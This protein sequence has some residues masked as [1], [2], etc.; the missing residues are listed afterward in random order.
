M[1]EKSVI[2]LITR[3]LA[4]ETTA[5]EEEELRY[6]LSVDADAAEYFKVC[7]DIWQNN[8]GPGKESA[9]DAFEK[10]LK[11]FEEDFREESGKEKRFRL[12]T[13]HAIQK[14]VWLAAA[15]LLLLA[16]AGIFW[17][18]V[19]TRS[20]Q[21]PDA[22]LAKNEVQS[23]NNRKR[24]LLPDSTVVWLNKNSRL[25]FSLENFSRDNRTVYLEGEGFFDVA[26]MKDHPFIIHTAGMDI[27]VLGTSF[28]V[29]AYQLDP[30]ETTL[31]SGAVELAVNNREKQ[32]LVLK[33]GEKCTLKKT[34]SMAVAGQQPP[35]QN[36]I[37]GVHVTGIEPVHFY[38]RDYIQEI[39]WM[40][41]QLVF[42]N[43]SFAE[44][45]Q[46]MSQWF[47]IPVTIQNNAYNQYHFTGAFE[48][49]NITEALKALQTI[50]P[51][52]Y[53]IHQNGVVIF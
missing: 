10:H 15:C 19:T 24:L 20:T 43:K 21:Q 27:K 23:G 22:L 48:K 49:E 33:A 9:A 18:S 46:E 29:K 6:L 39:A 7:S 17:W 4:G 38:N 51:F 3:K 13:A 35:Q 36:S 26:K 44:L 40:N 25:S 30:V 16:G 42:R 34:G 37:A 14:R 28:N 31:I 45:A 8:P 32:T 52:Q 5:E 2:Q 53:T 12:T 41:N 11:R 47:N 1:L 50:R